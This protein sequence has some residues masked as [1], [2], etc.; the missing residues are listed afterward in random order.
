[1]REGYYKTQNHFFFYKKLLFLFRVCNVQVFLGLS[2][3][4]RGRRVERKEMD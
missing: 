1:M 4:S 3:D 2:I